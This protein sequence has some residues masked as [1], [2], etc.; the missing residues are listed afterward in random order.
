MCRITDD[1]TCV[2]LGLRVVA[3]IAFHRS[4]FDATGLNLI[5]RRLMPRRLGTVI[6][7]TVYSAH[8]RSHAR[9][10]EHDGPTRGQR[11]PVDDG[12]RGRS[13]RCVC[14]RFSRCL[15]WRTAGV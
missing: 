9:T 4:Q 13:A 15:V 3:G 8:A 11:A 7:C 10:Q 1:Q 12:D 2:C 5:L 14:G 6:N